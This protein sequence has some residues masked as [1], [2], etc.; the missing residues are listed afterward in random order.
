[1]S[2]NSSEILNAVVSHAMSLGIFER[3]NTS[4]PKNS[5][6]SGV[7]A[8]IWLQT[9]SPVPANSG[10]HLTSARVEFIIR[11]YSNMMEEPQDAIDPNLM[12]SIDL[13]MATYSADFDLGGLVRNVDLLGAHGIGLAATAGYLDVSGKMYRIIDIVLPLIV[14][15]VWEQVS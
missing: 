9:I 10:L 8:A 12:G 2:L 11:L 6:G 3:V 13:L 15:D 5:P 4:E 1:M 7:T 14:N